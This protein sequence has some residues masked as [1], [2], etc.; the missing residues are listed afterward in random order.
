MNDVN[1]PK[2]NFNLSS[3]DDARSRANDVRDAIQ[4][5]PEVL[6]QLKKTQSFYERNRPVIVAAATVYVLM[7]LNKRML[8][9]MLASQLQDLHVVVDDVPIVDADA[10][11]QALLTAFRSG[12]DY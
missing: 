1:K 8:T 9:K 5:N 11:A 4:E 2:V 3:F 7:K 12:R 6:A 10:V